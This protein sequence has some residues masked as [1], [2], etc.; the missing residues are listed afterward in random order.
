MSMFLAFG[1]SPLTLT[2]LW[3]LFSVEALAGV[4]LFPCIW[5]PG[6]HWMS[7][8]ISEALGPLGSCW[9][10]D[11]AELKGVTLYS[12]FSGIVEA[13]MCR[14]LEDFPEHMNTQGRAEYVA[15]CHIMVAKVI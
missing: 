5:G 2:L 12:C 7:V 6:P 9:W 11:T 10:H 14:L 4:M 1:I 13:T 15:V 8:S 3:A